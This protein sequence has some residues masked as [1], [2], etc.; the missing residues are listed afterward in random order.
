VCTWLIPA[1]GLGLAV[2]DKDRP[3]LTVSLVLAFVTLATNKPYLG[4]SRE[5]WDPILFGV[6]LV[7]VATTVRRWLARGPGAQRGGFTAD[8]ILERDRDW[9]GT[10][11]TAS[12]AWPHDVAAARPADSARPPQFDGGRSGGAGGGAEY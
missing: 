8:K 7:V 3:L 4:L 11:A 9:L 10:L 1:A 12:V 2:R 5:S 6:L